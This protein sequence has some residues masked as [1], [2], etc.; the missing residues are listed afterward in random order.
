MKNMLRID[1]GGNVMTELSVAPVYHARWPG[2]PQ[3]LAPQQGMTSVNSVHYNMMIDVV[4]LDAW[5]GIK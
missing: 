4:R 3:Q 1:S 5:P 2:V